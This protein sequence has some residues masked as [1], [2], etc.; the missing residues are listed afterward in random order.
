MA[1]SAGHNQVLLLW[2]TVQDHFQRSLDQVRAQMD[3]EKD[4]VDLYRLQGEA[5]RLKILLRLPESLQLVDQQDKE[6]QKNEA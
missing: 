5:R 6:D 2:T 3:E 4:S 1:S